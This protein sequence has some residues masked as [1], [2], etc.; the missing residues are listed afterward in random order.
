MPKIKISKIAKDFNIALSTA[1]EFLRKK[2]IQIDDNPNARVD[3]EAY[4]ML[5]AEFDPDGKLR[6]RIAKAAPAP[7]PEVSKKPKK[8]EKPEPVRLSPIKSDTTTE[9]PTEKATEKAP[10]APAG[11]K[12]LG[13]IDLDAPK[14]AKT[15][16]AE[17][18]KVSEKSDDVRLSPI[19]SEKSDNTPKKSDKPEV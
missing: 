16:V 18:P 6:A 9:K 11:P 10:A 8:S 19:K 1:V 14:P 5:S 15:E 3:D 4:A 12:I 7:K 2:N 13:K 17:K